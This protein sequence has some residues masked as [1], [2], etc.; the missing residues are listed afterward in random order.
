MLEDLESRVVLYSATGNAWPAAQLVTIS[1]VPD[2]TILGGKASNLFANFNAKFGSASAWENIILKAAQTWAQ[3]TNINFAVVPDNGTPA[4]RAPT[5]RATRTSA[6]SASAA[7][8]STAPPWPRPVCR[9]RSNNYSVAGDIQFNTGQTFNIGTTYDL[10]VAAHEIGHALGLLP[11]RDR[12]RRDVLDLQRR[13]DRADH[14]RHRRHPEPSTADRAGKTLRRI[15]PETV[16]SAPPHNINSLVSTS[17]LTGL[18]AGAD[19]TT[20]ADKDFF[21]VNCRSGT[22]GTDEGDDAKQGY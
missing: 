4:A 13:Q 10:T 11:Q 6:T 16:P 7:T 15:A 19:I 21:V 18:V 2:G 5:S 12:Q 3:Q 9:R 20:P 1:F 17:T 22:N 8:T 14:R